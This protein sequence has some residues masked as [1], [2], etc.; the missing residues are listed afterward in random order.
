MKI[1][2]SKF[3]HLVRKNIVKWLNKLL[4]K[5]FELTSSIIEHLLFLGKLSEIAK[6]ICLVF[7]TP[8]IIILYLKFQKKEKKLK[9]LNNIYFRL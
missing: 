2:K 3:P 7:R 6:L 5:K 1:V 4:I 8:L 9:I